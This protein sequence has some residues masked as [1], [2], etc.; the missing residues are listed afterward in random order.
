MDELAASLGA[1]DLVRRFVNIWTSAMLGVASTD[2]SAIY[3]LHYCRCGGGLL[4]MRSDDKGGG[5][6]LRFRSGTQTLATGLSD[7]LEPG[8]VH[9]SEVVA[10]VQQSLESGCVVTTRDGH[11]FR[12]KKVIST[13]PSPL[14]QE[15]SISPPLSVDKKWLVSQSRLG[16]YAKV[17]LSYAEPWWREAGLCGL[18]QGFDGP[19]T[20]TRDT[21]SDADGFFALT[22]FVVGKSGR[23]WSRE[24]SR[25]KRLQQ[26]LVH[27]DRIYGRSCPEPKGA[28]EQLWNDEE[29]SQ[30][31]PC[32]VVP[33]GCL[34]ALSRDQWRAEGHLHFA[35]TETSTIWKGYM[36]GALI[37]GARM[38]GEVI[39]NLRPERARAATR[40]N[41]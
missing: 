2:T 3:F 36:E 7:R 6:H 25:K 37:S 20:L 12:S 35:G 30:G 15:M 28:Q 24:P 18:S 1:T 8:S 38:A 23:R 39:D 29:F 31:A 11:V 40:G 32:P 26:V 13:V 10:E 16:F 33:A 21:S 4:Q 14:L 17:Y 27:I 19:V 34:E 41:L 9:F 5:Q 22:C